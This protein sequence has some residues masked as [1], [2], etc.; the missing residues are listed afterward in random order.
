ML[1]SDPEELF[2]HLG[3]AVAVAEGL[4]ADARGARERLD[5]FVGVLGGAGG[6]A[7]VGAA[8]AFG[9]AEVREIATTVIQRIRR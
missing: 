5:T 3:R 1:R 8:W 2:V 4:S 7:F 9:I 6:L